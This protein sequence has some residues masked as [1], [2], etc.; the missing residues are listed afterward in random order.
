MTDSE[1]IHSTLHGLQEWFKHTF[2]KAGW[3]VLAHYRG[4]NDPTYNSKLDS[5]VHGI[6][7][8]N[9]YLNA[10]S[11]NSMGNNTIVRDFP[12]M[13]KNLTHLLNFISSLRNTILSDKL[14]SSDT[15]LT[16]E[17]MTLCAM[18]HY[19]RHV[20]EKY[21]WMVLTKAKLDNGDYK[22]KLQNHKL[23]KL[24]LYGESLE[25]LT[26]SLLYRI[27][28]CNDVD[29]NN[30]EVDL[31]SMIK[32]LNVLKSCFNGHLMAE[33]INNSPSRKSSSRLSRKLS[34]SL[35]VPADV[36]ATS[37]V[38]M[39]QLPVV[40]VSATSVDSPSLRK[41]SS[42][43]LPTPAVD[44]ADL[45]ATSV[46]SPSLRKR[47]SAKLPTPAVDIADLSATSSVNMSQ[48]PVVDVSITSVDSPS[49]RKRSSAKLP[50]PTI[51][52]VDVSRT[53]P[54]NLPTITPI[55]ELSERSELNT[56][57]TTQEGGLSD[58]EKIA[59]LFK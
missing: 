9:K 36:S 44:I 43:K 20:F 42:A 31:A 35:P 55:N 39:S 24:N 16:V 58:Y 51:D 23:K 8:L 13:S 48:L 47:S 26:Q 53:S 45:S 38:N 52:V 12:V 49:L 30:V 29:K 15:E 7:R 21:G 28:T 54:A 41:R 57:T 1:Q 32:N 50:T 25:V 11:L 14:E 10:R 37:S 33:S 19:Y 34:L 2:E 40:D 22:G 5:Y 59:Q 46:D 6:N 3:M 17:D 27:R 18:Q 56:N 4:K